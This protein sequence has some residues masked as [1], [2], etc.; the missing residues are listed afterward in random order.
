[1]VRA[2]ACRADDPGSIPGLSTC[3]SFRMRGQSVQA[4]VDVATSSFEHPLFEIRSILCQHNAATRFESVDLEVFYSLILLIRILRSLF[5][6]FE[7]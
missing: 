1:M 3:L 7:Y 4:P 5:F 6:E 2:S